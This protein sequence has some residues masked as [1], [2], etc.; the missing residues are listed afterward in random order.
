MS[1]CATDWKLNGI[2]IH[3]IVVSMFLFRSTGWFLV[4]LHPENTPNSQNQMFERTYIVGLTRKRKPSYNGKE[5][6]LRELS[7]LIR[8]TTPVMPRMTMATH[9]TTEPISAVCPELLLDCKSMHQVEI[10]MYSAV[11]MWDIGTL[12]VII[13]VQ[14]YNKLVNNFFLTF[15]I[16]QSSQSH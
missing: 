6:H 12:V 15:T 5:A 16:S 8:H 1:N 10:T 13:I 2:T 4:F 14:N 11:T 9:P 3:N 7:H